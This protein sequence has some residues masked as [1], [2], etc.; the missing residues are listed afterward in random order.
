[1]PAISLFSLKIIL[2]KRTSIGMVSYK[3]QHNVGSFK[4]TILTPNT[5]IYSCIHS[6]LQQT[7]TELSIH[8][9]LDMFPRR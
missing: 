6:L 3:K 1:M 2:W 7:L 9:M 4:E 8:W 5:F